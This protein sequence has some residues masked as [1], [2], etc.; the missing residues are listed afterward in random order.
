MLFKDNLEAL[1]GFDDFV[2]DFD[3]CE[4]GGRGT[5]CLP[6]CFPYLAFFLCILNSLPK[7]LIEL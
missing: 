6:S 2:L 3:T 4:F 5:A 1:C 7:L